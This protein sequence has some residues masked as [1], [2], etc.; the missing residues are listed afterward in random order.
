MD[1]LVYSPRRLRDRLEIFS[2]RFSPGQFSH[3]FKRPEVEGLCRAGCHAGRLLSLLHEL[4]AE[5]ALL[6]LPVAPEARSPERAD[7]ETGV[8]ADALLFVN[9]DHPVFIPLFDS[10]SRADLHASRLPAVHA[11]HG[12]GPIGHFRVLPAP[13]TGHPAPPHAVFEVVKALAGRLAGMALN[14]TVGVKI[15]S[16]LSGYHFSTPF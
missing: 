5:I 3:F 4:E 13:E 6:H 10:A 15:K 12:D 1:R 14:A 9:H 16:E 11:G 7:R 8:A 2:G